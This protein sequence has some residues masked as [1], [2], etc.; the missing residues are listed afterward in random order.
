MS[1][2]VKWSIQQLS[3]ALSH[4][5]PTQNTAA[6]KHKAYPCQHRFPDHNRNGPCNSQSFPFYAVTSTRLQHTP[7]Q[8]CH[9]IK[10][11]PDRPAE[12]D[13]SAAPHMMHSKQ[14]S[15][16]KTYGGSQVRTKQICS[17]MDYR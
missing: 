14:I 16:P 1:L 15:V 2:A 17:C 8:S 13:T 9:G 7:V 6:V 3:T 12:T 10:P 5:L 4:L 11:Q